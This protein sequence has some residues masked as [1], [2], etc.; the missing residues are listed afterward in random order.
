MD[1]DIAALKSLVRERSLSLDVVVSAIE[2]ALTLAYQRVP[3]HAAQARVELD[4]SSGHVTVWA[5]ELDEEG[6][7]VGEYDDTPDGFLPDAIQILLD[8]P[9]MMSVYIESGDAENWVEAYIRPTLGSLDRWVEVDIDNVTATGDVAV[10]V[11]GGVDVGAQ[12]A[13]GCE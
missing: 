9:F 4:R 10:A 12:V 7:Q 3:G 8:Q 1:I 5:A 13:G 6:N 11:H 2:D